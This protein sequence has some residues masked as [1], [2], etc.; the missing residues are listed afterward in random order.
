[1]ASLSRV[2]CVSLLSAHRVLCL[3]LN[4][5]C[6]CCV[7]LGLVLV[8]CQ[9]GCC[10][11]VPGLCAG[12]WCLVLCLCACAGCWCCVRLAA[13]AVSGCWGRGSGLGAGCGGR[14]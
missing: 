9:T 14:V 3:L 1:M 2:A 4:T 10:V 7:R 8:L 12:A 6:W 11:L 5:G 13:G